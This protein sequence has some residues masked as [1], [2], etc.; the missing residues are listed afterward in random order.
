MGLC[1]I[2]MLFVSFGAPQKAPK[3]HRQTMV[4]GAGEG[5]ARTGGFCQVQGKE[6]IGHWSRAPGSTEGVWT[7]KH[8]SSVYIYIYNIYIYIYI[9]IYLYIDEFI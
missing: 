2:W 5:A 9:Y 3:I 7:F 1:I 8:I 6:A 4:H